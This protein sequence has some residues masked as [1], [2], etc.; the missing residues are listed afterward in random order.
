MSVDSPIVI[1]YDGSEP[2]RAAVREAAALFAPRRAIV[3]TVWEP[4]LNEFMLAPDP[5]GMGTTMIP[6]DPAV[7]REVDRASEDHALDIAHDGERLARE[8]GLDAEALAVRDLTDPAD[9][10]VQRAAERDAAAIVIGS[11]GLRGLKSKLLGSTSNAVLHRA[12]RPVIV[13]R[14][15]AGDAEAHDAN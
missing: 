1:A 9:A 3:L 8:A 4:G 5:T 12:G 2:A 10:I 14:H 13:V 7:V 11:R 15:A 6:Y